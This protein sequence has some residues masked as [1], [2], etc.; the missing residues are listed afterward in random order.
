MHYLT[1]RIWVTPGNNVKPDPKPPNY[2]SLASADRILS[3]IR[4]TKVKQ[5]TLLFVNIF[6]DELLWLILNAARSLST[7]RLKTEGLMK[8]LP[9]RL[10]KEALLEA[11]IELKAYWD[12]TDPVHRGSLIEHDFSFSD[13]PLQAAFEL[14]RVKCEV[15]STLGDVEEDIDEESQLLNQLLLA[16]SCS[17]RASAVAP[18]ALYIAVVLEHICE[19]VLS[20]VARV[21]ARD[22]SRTT[23]HIQDLHVALCEDETVYPL[24]KRMKVRE[25][26]EAQ[27]KPRRSKSMTTSGRGSP[28]TTRSS[29]T[30]P[31]PRASESYGSI[32]TK[33]VRTSGESSSAPHILSSPSRNSTE[34]SRLRMFG[35]RASPT[36]QSG[37]SSGHKRSGSGVSD[38]T[39]Q[40]V[41]TLQ[42][43]FDHDS[44]RSDFEDLMKSGTTMKVS[45]TPDRLKTFEVFSKEKATRG[46][47]SNSL[48]SVGANDRPGAPPL[49]ASTGLQPSPSGPKLV[50]KGSRSN[51]VARSAQVRV[52]SI[53]ED[54]D[55]DEDEGTSPTTGQPKGRSR[56]QSLAQ[57]LKE[58]PPWESNL[59]SS[60]TIPLTALPPVVSG[61][62]RA[63]TT[64]SGVSPV[65]ANASATASPTST[66]APRRKRST[67]Y[68]NQDSSGPSTP[69]SSFS[70]SRFHNMMRST[71]KVGPIPDGGRRPRA[72]E[73]IDIDDLLEDEEEDS[74]RR[75]PKKGR[76]SRKNSAAVGHAGVSASTREMIDFLSEGPPEPPANYTVTSPTPNQPTKSKPTGRFGRMISRLAK[77][78]SSEHMSSDKKKGNSSD[79]G[80]SPRQTSSG[81]SL[82]VPTASLPQWTLPTPPPPPPVLPP[83][84]PQSFNEYSFPPALQPPPHP[85]SPL[86]G[87][88]VRSRATVDKAATSLSAP[89][90]VSLASSSPSH[91]TA[92]PSVL[93]GSVEEPF[94][95]D[96]LVATP[97][98]ESLDDLLRSDT[99]NK[100][101]APPAEPCLSPSSG[102]PTRPRTTSS[103]R[104]RPAGGI[105]QTRPIL[106]V[107][108]SAN[109][110]STAV[111]MSPLK[112]VSAVPSTDFPVTSR[113]EAEATN[114]ANRSPSSTDPTPTLPPDTIVID[115]S[116]AAQMRNMIARATSVEECRVLVE[117]F[118]AQWGL[119]RQSGEVDSQRPS[120][121][122]E[123]APTDA[124]HEPPLVET[125]LGDSIP[126]SD[127]R[128]E[129][130]Q[131]D[132]AHDWAPSPRTPVEDRLHPDEFPPQPDSQSFTFQKLET[133]PTS[134]VIA[135]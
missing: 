52:S 70:A 22:S 56:T 100:L 110:T 135:A 91:P 105:F 79:A 13:F 89:S 99:Q 40:S 129:D 27:S 62:A 112:M 68:I 113:A 111:S 59:S 51:L 43:L 128:S 102:S 73:D 86:P 127:P 34:R 96:P 12:R 94:R 92:A 4:P 101:L 25:Q 20:N 85:K 130:D 33:P 23:A 71:P 125:L 55:E 80:S 116:K 57:F 72:I 30:S 54:E 123:L 17:P 84:P 15:Y 106:D 103:S 36:D 114:V 53:E 42:D 67:P 117:M 74:V 38:G 76:T 65:L 109:D 2:L 8:I 119:P 61:R 24:Y 120:L 49:P 83:E 19:H 28:T 31:Q 47:R 104:P 87:S 11:E 77:S 69:P 66:P 10:G 134:P 133:H 118:L 46:S 75:S 131:T 39:K 16:S 60:A 97:I 58:P 50:N 41:T 3:E 107:P 122:I 78:S 35:P 81:G 88:H 132:D 64:G 108:A 124:I 48:S 18:A 115:A 5:E 7:E 126:T 21:V 9:T 1:L 98:V 90:S 29:T 63:Q 45:L 32:G 37:H 26:L 44:A 121:R 95:M 14:M 6:V 82:K 93:S